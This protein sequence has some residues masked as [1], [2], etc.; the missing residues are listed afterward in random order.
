VSQP[1]AASGL[2]ETNQRIANIVVL[3]AVILSA[4]TTIKAN[5]NCYLSCD[6][7]NKP[8]LGLLA[9]SLVLGTPAISNTEL[10][11]YCLLIGPFTLD[12]LSMF[13]LANIW[14]E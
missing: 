8:G 12:R 6:T 7:T 3:L 2:A 1:P 10:I 5:R 14:N 9:S 11:F 13:G 4:P